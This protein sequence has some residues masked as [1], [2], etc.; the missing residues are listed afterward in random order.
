MRNTAAA[1]TEFG[2]A[3]LAE[4]VQFVRGIT[5]SSARPEKRR[6]RASPR[7]P[8]CGKPPAGERRF[9]PQD[10]RRLGALTTLLAVS[11]VPSLAFAGGDAG[12][13]FTI[14]GYYLIDFAVF[15]GIIVYFGRKP[16]AAMLDQRYKTV[17]ADIEQAKALREQAEAKH[18][19][20]RLRLERLEDELTKVMEDVKAGTEHEVERILNDAQLEADRIALDERARLAQE[21]KKIRQELAAHAAKMAL[22]L[23]EK[24]VRQRLAA[25]AEQDKL[26][27]RNLIELAQSR[28]EVA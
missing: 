1:L 18:E 23:A 25:P 6:F 15:V 14:H 26:V 27:Q 3:L 7:L 19:E 9:G 24:Q 10:Q 21:S 8:V 11:L 13:E 2:K 22:E 20:Y 16:I 4:P 28:K 5:E 12:F 17:A